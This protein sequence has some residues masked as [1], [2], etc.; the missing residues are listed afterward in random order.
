MGQIKND[1]LLTAVK[2]VLKELRSKTGLSQ[3]QVANDI[4]TNKNLSIHIARNE[5]ANLNISISTL[6]ELCEY[7]QISVSDFFKR[8]EEVNSELLINKKDA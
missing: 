4:K 8:V 7:Y 5:S 2:L 1:K 3:E 6:Y